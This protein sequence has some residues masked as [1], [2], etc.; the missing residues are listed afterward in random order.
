GDGRGP[1]GLLPRG[2][3]RG[4]I[5]QLPREAFDLHGRLPVRPGGIASR[6]QPAA[7]RAD[8]PN[9]WSMSDIGPPRK[10]PPPSELRIGAPPRPVTRLSRRTLVVATAFVTALIFAALWYALGIRP[11]RFA[12]GPELYNTNAKPTDALVNMRDS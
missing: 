9:G 1:R 12:G 7:D 4:R 5:R 2:D 8:Q 11:I 6:L 3:R 10:E